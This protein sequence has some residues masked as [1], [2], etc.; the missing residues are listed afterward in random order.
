[1]KITCP[2]CHAAYRID[3]PDPGEAGIDVQC[4]K[5]LYIFLFTPDIEIPGPSEIQ[6][7]TSVKTRDADLPEDRLSE[8]ILP[9]QKD[10][11]GKF[12]FF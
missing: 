5:C 1:M 9:P 7:G 11:A 10:E 8:P 4:G 3:L 12:I 2:K 6:S